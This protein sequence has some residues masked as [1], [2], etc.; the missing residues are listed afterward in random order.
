MTMGAAATTTTIAV[1]EAHLTKSGKVDNA[2]AAVIN[3]A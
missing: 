1:I 3:I 2:F